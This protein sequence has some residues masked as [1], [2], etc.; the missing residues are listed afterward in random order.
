MRSAKSG[1]GLLLHIAGLVVLLACPATASAQDWI[2]P[3]RQ[4]DTPWSICLEHTNK[5]GC[6]IELSRYNGIDRDRRI[7]IGTEIRVPIDWLVTV[8]A[9]G[10]ALS[11]QGEVMYESRAG[12]AAVPLQAGQPL[13]LGSRIVAANGSVSIQLNNGSQLLLRQGA[14][15]ELNALSTDPGSASAT[16]LVLP[17]GEVDVQVPPSPESRFEVRTPSAIA[18]VRGTSYRLAA[19]Q[20][21]GAATRGEV[22]TGAVD[23]RAATAQR[24]EA[25]FGVIAKKDQPVAPPR[26][27]LDPPA[28][29][30]GSERGPLP[31]TLR[32]QPDP[33]A[34]AWRLDVYAPGGGTLPLETRRTLEPEA[35]FEGLELACYR[36]V[37]L[38]VDADDFS[39]MPVETALCAEPPPPPAPEEWVPLLPHLM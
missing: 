8:P 37:L 21:G 24:V 28:I 10:T 35:T 27:L 14:E 32:W 13:L 17:R 33:L 3:I 4:G 36:V 23:V 39:G 31:L 1:N 12:A 18:A 16:E 34:V 9:V 2:Y 15:L 38:A 7:P 29:E 25:G 26:A 5:P 19:L 30:R 22:V 6:W 11:L 20:D